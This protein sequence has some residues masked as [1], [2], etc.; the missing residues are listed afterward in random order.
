MAAKQQ[1]GY[2]AKIDALNVKQEQAAI[3]DTWQ[4]RNVDQLRQWRRVSQQ[5][6]EQRAGAAAS[7]LDVNFG[8]AGE[9]QQ[10][11]LQIG[12]E[13]SSTLNQNAIKEVQG[14]D[15]N[16]ANY[17][18]QGAAAKARG[19]AAMT[20][21]ILSATGTLLSGASQIGKINAAPSMSANF[22]PGG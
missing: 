13:D 3:A 9:G 18:M 14:F 8:S 12:A 7:G 11:I 19:K 5:L 17:T 4:R 10:D 6:G 21:A 20:G 1:A 22:G 16:I 2:E 15:I